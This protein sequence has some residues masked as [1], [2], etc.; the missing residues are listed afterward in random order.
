VISIVVKKNRRGFD[1]CGDHFK[2]RLTLR[3][4][5]QFQTP[6]CQVQGGKAKCGAGF[7][8]AKKHLAAQQG[9]RGGRDSKKEEEVINKTSKR[10]EQGQNVS[11]ESER[12]FTLIHIL[13]VDKGNVVL[14]NRGVS[15]R[16]AQSAWQLRYIIEGTRRGKR[17]WG[18]TMVGKNKKG[19]SMAIWGSL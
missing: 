11:K 13:R 9:R 15:T 5:T 4:G 18:E 12:G 8:L 7:V 19:F 2:S 14:E 1:R 3:T 16:R 6:T 10:K 17:E